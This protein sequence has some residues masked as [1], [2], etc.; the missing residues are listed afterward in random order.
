M[1]ELH[2]HWVGDHSQCLDP[3]HCREWENTRPAW[4]VPN[5]ADA[6]W[7]ELLHLRAKAT[8]LGIEVDESWPIVQ[9]REEIAKVGD[10]E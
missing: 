1:P 10:H 7:A 9:L 8:E 3:D 4:T 2:G 5:K 6:A